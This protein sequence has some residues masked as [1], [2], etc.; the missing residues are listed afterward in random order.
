M[1]CWPEFS[2]HTRRI[3]PDMVTHAARSLDMQASPAPRLTWRDR[4]A[5][6]LAGAAVVLL[7]TAGAVG[8]TAYLYQ[9]F[10]MATTVQA[11]SQAMGIDRILAPAVAAERRLPAG[12]AVT[13]L[14]GT[15]LLSDPASHAAAR[16][17]DRGGSKRQGYHGVCPRRGSNLGGRGRWQRVLAGAYPGPGVPLRLDAARLNE[18]KS[19]LAARVV[20]AGFAPGTEP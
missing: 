2:V 13:I 9:R 12:S 4:P 14:A 19:G 5:S 1:R 11:S 16:S 10:G 3:S 20:T 7:S 6:L 18:A 8:S 17:L 15:F